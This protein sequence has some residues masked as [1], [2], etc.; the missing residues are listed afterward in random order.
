MPK[1]WCISTYTSNGGGRIT[2][3]YGH[4]KVWARKFPGWA[5]NDTTP[6]PGDGGRVDG[7]V[8]DG[9]G[10]SLPAALARLG[11]K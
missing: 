9:E 2:T 3:T 1:R 10:T 7:Q 5:A 6:Q 11:L 4:T 8:M